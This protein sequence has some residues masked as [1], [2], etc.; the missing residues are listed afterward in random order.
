MDNLG[1]FGLSF[2]CAG[3]A[4][5]QFGPIWALIW[6]RRGS[7][8]A[9]WAYLGPRLAAQGQHLGNLGLFGPSFGY[10]GV[11]F[12]QFGP[13]WTVIWLHRGSIW[14]IWAYLGPHLAAQGQSSGDPWPPQ[15]LVSLSPSAERS[16]VTCVWSRKRP[17]LAQLGGS[18]RPSG[19][20]GGTSGGPGGDF[21]LKRR[22][23]C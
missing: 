22:V 6:L 5:G 18:G 17:N 1:L 12:G 15:A 21:R 8:W 20:S 16:N 2:G 3:V 19:D 13:I 10:T 7:I 11:A 4:F 9:I 23:D 14:G